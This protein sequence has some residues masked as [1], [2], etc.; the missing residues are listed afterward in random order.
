M[1]AK[2][3]ERIKYEKHK[4]SN[5]RKI[6]NIRKTIIERDRNLKTNNIQHYE[7]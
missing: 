3:A 6:K 4:K 2:D 7:K 1:M 5:K